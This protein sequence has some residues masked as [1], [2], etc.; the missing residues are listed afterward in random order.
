MARATRFCCVASSNM[1]AFRKTHNIYYPRMKLGHPPPPVD[2]YR[3][4]NAL[5]LKRMMRIEEDA[6]YQLF[7][8][9]PHF[10]YVRFVKKL[11]LCGKM[12]LD[13][14]PNDKILDESKLKA[15]ADDKMK[16]NEN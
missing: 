12:L 6:G 2:R 16:M 5:L 3:A 4:V 7:H 11:G 8:I 13:S 14:L 1:H 10:Y 15:S 9:F